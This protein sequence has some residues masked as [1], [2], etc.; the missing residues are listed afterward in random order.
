MFFFNQTARKY[1]V[2][3]VNTEMTPIYYIAVGK[4][5]VC[6]KLSRFLH[7]EGFYCMTTVFPAIARKNSGLRVTVNNHNTL[8]DIDALLERIAYALPKFLAEENSSMEEIYETFGMT[9]PGKDITPSIE[10]RKIA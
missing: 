9:L 5:E 10:R 8:Q 4:M 1:G 3:V 6:Y 2:P 7:D